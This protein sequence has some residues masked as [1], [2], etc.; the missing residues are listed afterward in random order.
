[1]IFGKI[2]YRSPIF[3]TGKIW[4]HSLHFNFTFI[5]MLDFGKEQSHILSFATDFA[6]PHTPCKVFIII[7]PCLHK[8]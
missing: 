5:E 6:V 3:Y 7:L 8:L 2:R 1:M 4:L